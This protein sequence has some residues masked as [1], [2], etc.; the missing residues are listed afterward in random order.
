MNPD[1]GQDA[2]TVLTKPT[3]P[4]KHKGV[5]GPRSAPPLPLADLILIFLISLGFLMF[6]M[7]M[8]HPE[9]NETHHDQTPREPKGRRVITTRR[10]PFNVGVA[11]P[12]RP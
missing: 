9:Q 1:A 8:I 10:W 11:F 12:L 4:T 2:L 3:K 7:S 5:N 6:S